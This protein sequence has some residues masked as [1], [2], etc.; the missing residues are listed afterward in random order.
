LRPTSNGKKP[1]AFEEN[2]EKGRNRITSQ[3][4]KGSERKRYG[5]KSKERYKME[6]KISLGIRVGYS[7]PYLINRPSDVRKTRIYK[8]LF[9]CIIRFEL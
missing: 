1:S 5:N 3:R 7:A 8:T 6:T 9:A 2:V 4:E